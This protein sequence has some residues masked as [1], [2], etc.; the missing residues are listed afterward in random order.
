VPGQTYPQNGQ[1]APT[2]QVTLQA[3]DQY[4]GG[5]RL[6]TMDQLGSV[7]TYF[8]WGEAK[9]GTNPQDTWSFAM[10]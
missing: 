3:S 8:P 5:R 7:G 6:A 1:Y 9:G 10:Y 2:I 4:F